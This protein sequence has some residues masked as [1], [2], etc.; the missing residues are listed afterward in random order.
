MC[1][2]FDTADVALSIVAVSIATLLALGMMPLLLYIYVD[3]GGIS[4]G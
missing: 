3:A 2:D 4:D 1:S